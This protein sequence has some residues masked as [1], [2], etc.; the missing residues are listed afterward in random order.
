MKIPPNEAAIS[1]LVIIVSVTSQHKDKNLCFEN[2]IYQAVLLGDVSAPSPFRMPLQGFW[3]TSASGGVLHQFLQQLRHF[4]ESSWFLVLQL[5]YMLPRFV[6]IIK[7]IHGGQRLLRKLCSSSIEF[8]RCVLPWR[9]S[10]SPRSRLAMNSSFETSVSSSFFAVSFLAYLNS[11]AIID[12]SS[13]MMLNWRN[14]S[15]FNCIAVIFL[16]I[17]VFRGQN[18]KINLIQPKQIY[19]L[20]IFNIHILKNYISKLF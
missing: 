12:S 7:L 10:S 1:L 13:A 11:F 19:F 4:L 2:T 17:F 3:V 14:N 18:Y 5:G 9:Y 20:F 16:V 6:G 15:A 8:K